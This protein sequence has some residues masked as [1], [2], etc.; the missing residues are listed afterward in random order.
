[1]QPYHCP[2]RDIEGEMKVDYEYFQELTSLLITLPET[3]TFL[4]SIVSDAAIVQGEILKE[5]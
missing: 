4:P 1:M 5:R 2:G 3:F